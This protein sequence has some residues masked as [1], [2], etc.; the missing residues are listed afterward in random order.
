[1]MRY[2]AH[3]GFVGYTPKDVQSMAS[4]GRSVAFYIGLVYDASSHIASPLAIVTS[5]GTQQPS[6]VDVNFMDSNVLDLF[7]DRTSR[8]DSTRS[9]LR[10]R[11]LSGRKLAYEICLLSERWTTVS[12]RS[13]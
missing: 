1:V 3:V 11:F 9:I 12:Q 7:V 4:T 5:A 6:G 8:N 13:A 10:A 2:S